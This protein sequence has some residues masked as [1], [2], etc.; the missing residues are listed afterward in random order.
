MFFQPPQAR[1]GILQTTEEKQQAILRLAIV[2]LMNGSASQSDRTAALRIA[3]QA[4][5]TVSEYL[6]ARLLLNAQGEPTGKNMI[7]PR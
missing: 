2:S 1:T 4:G 7:E 5:V 3:E 6:H